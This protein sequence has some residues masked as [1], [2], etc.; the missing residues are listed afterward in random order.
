MLQCTIAGGR[1][2]TANE[3]SPPPHSQATQG[4]TRFS[5]LNVS[6]GT[7]SYGAFLRQP[8]TYSGSFASTESNAEVS[9][10]RHYSP[11]RLWHPST[12]G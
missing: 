6:Q 10:Q 4:G 3:K 8:E 5:L 9:L 11:E 1:T 12:G 7:L 2:K